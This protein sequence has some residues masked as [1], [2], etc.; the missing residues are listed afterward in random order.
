MTMA[1]GLTTSARQTITPQL[2]ASIRLLQLDTPTLLAE[3]EQALAQNV[4][5][6]RE[7]EEPADDEGNDTLDMDAVM[8]RGE[9]E[10]P[11]EWDEHLADLRADY[12][13]H[14]EREHADH[15]PGLQVQLLEAL[16]TEVLPDAVRIA[17]CAVL[18]QVD[19]AGR[20]AEPLEAIAEATGLTLAALDAGLQALRAQAPSGY[21]ATSVEEC[22]RLQLE[23]QDPDALR[24]DALA[25]LEGGLLS[26][27]HFGPEGLRRS[28][29]FDEP[30]FAAALERLRLLD[31]H[32]GAEAEAPREVTPDLVVI[33]R[34][35]QWRIELHPWTRPR[36]GI[37]RDYERLIAASRNGTEGLRGQLQDARALLRGLAMRNDTLLRTGRAILHYQF[38][39]LTGGDAALRPLRLRDI[40]AAIGM[41][42]STVSRVTTG[43]YV[44]TPRGLFELRHFFSTTLRG[45]EDASAA[46]ARARI[47]QLVEGED[48]AEPLSDAQ[49][50]RALDADNIHVVRR[51]VAKYR[52]AMGIPTASLR[53][54]TATRRTSRRA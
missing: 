22:L 34:G 13:P 42:E 6:E 21:A 25:V 52:N 24:D 30:R 28:L 50:A 54:L 15:E 33:R 7:A 51:T 41:H 40:A 11:R 16:R 37:N 46:S 45:D 4:M 44:Q 12:S 27:G 10:D 43:K 39:F 9:A 26:V 23:A 48:A 17:A 29:G 53:R 8:S 32:P 20:L 35:G 31:L 47:R 5:L 3:I 18:E 2:A 1:L 49:L 38:A 36:L 14:A 19:E